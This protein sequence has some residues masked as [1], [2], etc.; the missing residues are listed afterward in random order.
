MIEPSH[1]L[2]DRHL[3]VATAMS[4]KREPACFAFLSTTAISAPVA[5]DRFHFDIASADYHRGRASV[6]A[7]LDIMAD[8]PDGERM[9]LIGFDDGFLRP[10][11]RAVL[12]ASATRIAHR[13]RID[14]SDP[15]PP[16]VVD[17]VRS[18]GGSRLRDLIITPYDQIVAVSALDDGPGAGEETLF[19]MPRTDSFLRTLARTAHLADAALKQTLKDMEALARTLRGPV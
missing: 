13:M 17:Y 11:A 19:Q 1:P 2:S 10:F 9:S 14:C 4:C 6:W 15:E 16:R 12:E 18:L 3:D 7:T 8:L 5:I